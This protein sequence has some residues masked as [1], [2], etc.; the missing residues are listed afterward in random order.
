MSRTK[1]GLLSGF[2]AAMIFLNLPAVDPCDDLR[3]PEPRIAACSR[4]INSGKWEG[5]DQA[6]NYFNRGNAYH[7]KGD[8]DRAI[9]DYARAISIDPKFAIPYYNRGLIYNKKGDYDR[10]IAD[11]TQAI[12]V[13]PRYADS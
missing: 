1:W 11:Y 5:H 6:V 7:D 13:D 4:S 2:I 10:A 12:G 3:D 8:N 9:A